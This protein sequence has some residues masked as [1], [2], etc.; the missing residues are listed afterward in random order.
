MTSKRDP[1]LCTSGVC[2]RFLAFF[3]FFRFVDIFKTCNC[4]CCSAGRGK[5][6]TTTISVVWRDHV[7]HFWVDYALKDESSIS[8]APP[9]KF[10]DLVQLSLAVSKMRA[11]Q[12]YS[13][14]SFHH[15]RCLLW[16]TITSLQKV[17]WGWEAPPVWPPPGQF[18]RNDDRC[19][20]TVVYGI[21]SW[22][23]SHCNRFHLNYLKQVRSK[24]P[25]LP[26]LS[27]ST[28][29]RRRKKKKE[30]KT[31]TTAESETISI[32]LYH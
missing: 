27:H 4:H 10:A 16:F 29:Y 30:K 9:P 13:P 31:S 1:Q 15:V 21:T 7:Q 2:A 25:L 19:V 11:L 22:Q 28:I 6:I 18:R 8:V 3:F 20:V 17:D 23:Q 5:K 24:S 12:L 32:G 14:T 26:R